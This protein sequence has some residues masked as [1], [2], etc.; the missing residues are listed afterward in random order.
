MRSL[1]FRKHF[2]SKDTILLVLA[3]FFLLTAGINHHRNRKP[4][5]VVSKQDTA[6]NVNKDLLIFLSAGNKRLFSDL[7][8]VQTL[9]ESDL[10]QYSGRDLNNWLFLRFITVQALDPYFYENYLYGGQFLAIIKDDLEGANVL[11]TKGVEFYPNDYDL[12][13]HAGFMNYYEKGDLKTALKFFSRIENHP[14]LPI[15]MRSIINKLKYGL[16]ND[17]EATF[18]LVLFNYES[19]KDKT[20]KER[21]LNDLYAIRAEI[22]LAC[23]NQ[24]KKECN[25]KDIFGKAYIKKKDIYLAPREFLKYGVKIR[26]TRGED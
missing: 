24:G 4:S 25:Y 19:S 21:L 11:Y 26:K 5:L 23:L 10:D 22:D 18:K 7:V 20:L 9:L 15:F 3:V 12:N 1:R 6:L 13:F 17:L 14:R 2:L 8:W 16:S